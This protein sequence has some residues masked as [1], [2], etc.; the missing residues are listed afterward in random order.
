MSRGS[1]RFGAFLWG[2]LIGFVAGLAYAPRP[3]KE[4]RE[5]WK[6]KGED[7]KEK[8]DELSA[9]SNE[10][11]EK[12][13]EAW[14]STEEWRH[15]A[16]DRAME[17]KG[18]AQ[19]LGR[20]AAEGAEHMTDD[21]RGRFDELRSSLKGIQK[22]I[23]E[24]PLEG[25]EVDRTRAHSTLKGLRTRL[26]AARSSFKDAM[27]LKEEELKE[28]IDE[29]VEEKEVKAPKG[30]RKTTSRKSATDEATDEE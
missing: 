27:K 26:G 30:S 29:V 28:R 4:T 17:L 9:K 12:V 1:G 11:F 19:D 14:L 2:G 13:E 22:D 24:L 6:E 10:L 21:L 15:K 3:G 23:E 18:Q 16:R 8:L 7:L 25:E 5:I 20:K